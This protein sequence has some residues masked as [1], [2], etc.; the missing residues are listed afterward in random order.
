M[1]QKPQ[2][3]FRRTQHGS[4]V[5]PQSI[6]AATVAGSTISLPWKN[7]SEIRFLFHGGAWPATT[8]FTAKVQLQKISDDSWVTMTNPTGSDVEFLQTKLDDGGDGE[9]GTISGTL[10]LT[11]L[12]SATYKAMRI[13]V[14]NSAATLAYL[15]ISYEIFGLY[16]MEAGDANSGGL[17]DL[18]ELQSA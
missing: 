15:G 18:W 10:D 5:A 7:G 14:I 4:A 9:G 1:A 13:Q 11:S 3:L 6:S 8:N 16:S 17:D 2:Q 12:D